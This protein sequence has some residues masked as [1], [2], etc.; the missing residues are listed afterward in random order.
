[1]GESGGQVAVSDSQTN[2]SGV[3][4]SGVQENGPSESGIKLKYGDVV[5]IRTWTQSV[6]VRGTCVTS[7]RNDVMMS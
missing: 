4:W 7:S 6:Q 2:R 3:E 5:S 1:M